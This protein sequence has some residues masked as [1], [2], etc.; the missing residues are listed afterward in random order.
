MTA[1]GL[2]SN[3]KKETDRNKGDSAIIHPRCEFLR[4]GLMPPVHWVSEIIFR[5]IM[6]SDTCAVQSPET[7]YQRKFLPM[8]K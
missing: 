8:E 2:L 4:Q 1:C 7:R 5:G 3:K 6:I